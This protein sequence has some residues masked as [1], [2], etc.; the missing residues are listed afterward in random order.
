MEKK[1]E[2]R[3]LEEANDYYQELPEKIQEKFIISF[4]K[5]KNG[6]KGSWF[7]K[8]KNS[9]GI[10]EF[11]ERG[12][13]KFYRIFAFWDKSLENTTLIIATHGLDK[14]TNKT[15]QKEIAKAERIKK[16]YFDT[17]SKK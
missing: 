11:R 6:Y 10:F 4:Y 17:K 5:V 9:D 2:V 3:L 1:I 7:E 12:F 16:T 15:P 13:N 14:K 8:L